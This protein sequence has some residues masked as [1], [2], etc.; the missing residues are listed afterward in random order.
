MKVESA[1]P[2]RSRWLYGLLV[3][4]AMASGLVLRSRYVSLPAAWVKYGGDAVWALLVF[5]GFCWIF[6]RIPTWRLA[7]MAWAF[8][9]VIEF[10]QIYHAPWID[11]IRA[12]RAGHL[13]LGSTFNW[14]DLPSYVA[15]ILLGVLIDARI[16]RIPGNFRY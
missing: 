3:L 11:T 9:W 10:S 5:F 13:V 8:A 6:H 15:G 2:Q 7:L 4:A 12:T 1:L 14:P 16:R